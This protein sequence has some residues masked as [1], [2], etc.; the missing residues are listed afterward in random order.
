MPTAPAAPSFPDVLAEIAE[1][2]S[3]TAARYAELVSDLSHDR[4]K[5]Y[6]VEEVV[7]ICAA[8][9]RTVAELT[10]DV[11]RAV[12]RFNAGVALAAMGS[13]SRD[14]ERH[15][16]AR[17]TAEAERADALA[18]LD[19]K[20][21]AERAD[22]L[23][24]FSPKIAEVAGRV[25][26]ATARILAGKDA[27]AF[28]IETA[29]AAL[30]ERVESIRAGLKAARARAMALAGRAA[31]EERLA[32]MPIPRDID[33]RDLRLVGPPEADRMRRERAGER[34]AAQS[35]VNTAV[36]KLAELRPA[37]ERA[38]A[39]VAELEADLRE[40]ESALLVP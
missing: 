25:E 6:E 31:A 22:L 32:A 27:R 36:A 15:D 37:V 26:E 23:A 5:E 29:P 13:A 20:H 38:E 10:A 40:A 1:Y 18:K 12:D 9:G 24:K 2:E 17:Q 30:R 21:A 35:R 3:G 28:L 16:R 7:S 34:G 39:R 33:E 19:A 8:A 4:S 14:R 11:E